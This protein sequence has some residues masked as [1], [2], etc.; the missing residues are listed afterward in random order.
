MRKFRVKLIRYEM[1]SFLST[2]QNTHTHTH[3]AY[4][5]TLLDIYYVSAVTA[6]H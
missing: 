4:T 3:T 1:F 5:H 2:S 6:Q